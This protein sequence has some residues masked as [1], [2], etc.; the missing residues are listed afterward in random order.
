MFDLNQVQN[1]LENG[2]GEA[3]EL[4]Q[5]PSKVDELLMQMEAKLPEIP[6][7]GDVL[8]DV[9]RMIAMGKGDITKQYTQ[10]SGKVI[11]T[12]VAAFIYLVKRKDIIPDGIPI[13]GLLDDLGVIGAALK[14][15]GPELD[16]F[17]AWRDGT[18]E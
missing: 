3:R 7:G 18:Q 5:N 11:A 10:V 1:V 12:L 17:K 8:K 2:V 16:A 15:C 9:P 13:L 14:I 6:V 4:L